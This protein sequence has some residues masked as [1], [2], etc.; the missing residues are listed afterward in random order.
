MLMRQTP[1][2]I[3]LCLAVRLGARAYGKTVSEELLRVICLAVA[4]L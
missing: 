2:L 3:A 1:K 4:P